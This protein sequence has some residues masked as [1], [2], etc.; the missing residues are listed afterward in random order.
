MGAEVGG[1]VLGF[2][3][4]VGCP[5]AERGPGRSNLSGNESACEFPYLGMVALDDLW[6]MDLRV[7]LCCLRLKP[8]R[9]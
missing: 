2:V 3:R 7:S 8:T 1:G 9:I 4:V 5:A 6:Y